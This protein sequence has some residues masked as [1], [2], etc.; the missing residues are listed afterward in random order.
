MAVVVKYIHAFVVG[1]PEKYLDNPP[2]SCYYFIVVILLY[3]GKV[4]ANGNQRRKRT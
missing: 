1:R 4:V 3:Y 2:Y